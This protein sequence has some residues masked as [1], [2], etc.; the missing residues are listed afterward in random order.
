[1]NEKIDFV[2]TWVDGN[3]EKWLKEKEKY[4]KEC[5]NKNSD[6]FKKWINAKSRYRDWD[7]LKYWFRAVCKYAPWVNKIYFITYGHVPNWLDTNNPKLVIGDRLRGFGRAMI[8]EV[9]NK[10]NNVFISFVF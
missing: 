8:S 1:M 2:I 9:Y 7:N 10:W 6:E 5:S 3:D 4:S